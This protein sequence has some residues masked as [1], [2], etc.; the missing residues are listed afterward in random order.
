MKN[1]NNTN[2][3]LITAGRTFRMDETSKTRELTT[4]Y[5]R[6]ILTLTRSIKTTPR[7]YKYNINHKAILT[8]YVSSIHT[9][10]KYP[11]YPYDLV[12][13]IPIFAMTYFDLKSMDKYLSIKHLTG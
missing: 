12:Q 10:F 13:E 11:S 2:V 5:S 8:N 9:K 6:A 7:E 1:L 4:F 3:N